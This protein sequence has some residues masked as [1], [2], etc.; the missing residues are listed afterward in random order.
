MISS[1]VSRAT[2]PMPAKRRQILAG[3]RNVFGEL[4]FERAT[5]DLIAAR[6]GVSKATVYNH[7]ADKKALFVAAVVEESDEMRA[8][9]ERCLEKPPGDVE[10]AL[11][12]MGEKVIAVFLSR[13]IA[14]LY[15]EAISEA[16]RLPEIGRMVFERGTV[17]IQQAV[18]AHIS[19]WTEAGA[20]RV[21]DA[22]S[23]AI[24]FVALCH[25]DL[26]T[27]MRLGVLEGSVDDQI[28][29]TVKR[30]VRIFVRAYG[31]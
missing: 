11:Q 23:A 15:R 3:A 27:R 20:L 29:E 18:A 21:D 8:G 13:Q 30:A 24:A 28:R 9:L 14:S 7:F 31:Q 2:D 6:A 1:G 17:A 10:Q 26:V 19:R 22:R 12:S 25:G 16:A 5:V 4:G